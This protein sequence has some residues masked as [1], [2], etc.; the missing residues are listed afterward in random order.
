MEIL[1]AIGR[2][3]F[4]ESAKALWAT[5]GVG[6]ERVKTVDSATMSGIILVEPNGENRIAIAP[7][8]LSELTP[9]D[10]DAN[11]AAFSAA[12]IVVVCL[13][14]PTETAERAITVA[15]EQGAVV[16]L[17]PA[18][19]AALDQHVMA[20]AD[21]FIPNQ[22]EYDFYLAQGYAPPAGQTLVVTQGED[23]V[24]IQCDQLAQQVAPFPQE[25]VV[26]TTGA[27]D[28]FVGTFAAAIA[29]GLALVPA[30]QRAIVASSLSV[31]KA[32]VIPSIPDADTV[33]QKLSE[34]LK[35]VN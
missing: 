20:Q 34:Y 27:G 18:P 2:D 23:G 26:D 8:A 24:M 31:T 12:E 35:H 1:T 3:P 15:K 17:N 11:V 32:E 29:S 16:M 7:G 9:N 28:T 33:D 4:G 30:V 19:A 25:K 13:E 22:T 21:Y 5:E 14:I 10:I 6:Y